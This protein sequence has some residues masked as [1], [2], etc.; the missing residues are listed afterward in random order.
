MPGFQPGAFVFIVPE[1]WE[2]MDMFIYQLIYNVI[3]K[4]VKKPINNKTSEAE[5]CRIN[6]DAS[7]LYLHLFPNTKRKT[8]YLK[9]YS[10]QIINLLHI[11]SLSIME[12][13]K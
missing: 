13:Q 11:Q 2:R 9:N 10:H 5:V 12:E 7:D 4:L 6:L 8:I 3:D 1:M